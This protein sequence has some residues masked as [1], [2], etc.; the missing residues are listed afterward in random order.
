MVAR[1]EAVHEV[2][3]IGVADEKWGERPLALVVLKPEF[4][5]RVT[6]HAIRNFAAQLVES[7][8]ISRHSVLLQVRFIDALIKTS[9]GKINKREMR[10]AHENHTLL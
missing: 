8:K 6:E 4:V 7:T 1:H 5:G 3:V 9:V 10:Q 2:A